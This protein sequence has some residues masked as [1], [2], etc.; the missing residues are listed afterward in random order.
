MNN[1]ESDTFLSKDQ[2]ERQIDYLKTNKFLAIAYLLIFIFIFLC[3]TYEL[4]YNEQYNFFS[5]STYI[6][7][8]ISMFFTVKIALIQ[9]DKLDESIKEHETILEKEMV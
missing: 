8:L 5:L 6:L 4:F 9:R 2:R 3:L 1:T 7:C